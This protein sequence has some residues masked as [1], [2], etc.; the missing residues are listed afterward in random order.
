ME[1]G[2]IKICACIN[3]ISPMD[4][5]SMFAR[6]MNPALF[7]GKKKTTHQIRPKISIIAN[8]SVLAFILKC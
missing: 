4:D 3:R 5:S 7:S 1:S 8:S 2:I 6:L